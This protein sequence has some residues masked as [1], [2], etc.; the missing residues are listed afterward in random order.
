MTQSPLAVSREAPAFQ[1]KLGLFDATM[2]VAGS[3]IGSGIFAVSVGIARDVGSS[4]WLILVWLVSG[5]MTIIG[6]LSYAELASMFPHAGGQYVFLREAYGSLWAFLYGWTAFLVIQAGFIAAVAVIFATYLGV[7]FPNLGTESPIWETSLNIDLKVPVPWMSENVTFFKREKFTVSPGQFVAVV[8]IAVLTGLNCFGVGMGRWVQNIFTVAK[9]LGLLLLIVVGLT[10]AADVQFIATNA[11]DRWDGITSTQQYTQVSRFAPVPLLAVLLVLCGAM[12]GPLFS[13]DAWNNVTFTAGEVKNT[14]RNLPLSLGM[15][16]GMVILLYLLANVAYLCDLPIQGDAALAQKLKA[17]IDLRNAQADELA[18]EGRLHEAQ[19]A[20]QDAAAKDREATIAELKARAS[21]S[22]GGDL[23]KVVIVAL[24]QDVKKRKY[25]A[26]AFRDQAASSA[27]ASNA[28][29]DS[30]K[31]W[32]EEQYER[33]APRL[34]ISHARDDR[35]GTAV[36]ELF[37]PRFGVQ[38]MAL[39]IMISTFGCANGLILMGARLYY[40]MAKDGLFFQSVGRLN[41]F[42]VPAVGLILQ[43][44]WASL[45]AFS[46]TYGDLLYYVIFAALLF[47]ALTVVGL[48]VLRWKRPDAERPYKAIGYPV[49]PAIYVVLCTLIMLDLLV[50]EPTYTWPGLIIVLTGVP[51]YFL[52]RR[53][54]RRAQSIE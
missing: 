54:G 17:E 11:A 35:V 38:A 47:Y 24:E 48:F 29:R 10:W 41:R 25:E 12:V 31:Q 7:L 19:A 22:Q 50:V 27:A 36:M 44:I 33:A 13:S 2:L 9:T 5:V 40:A 51:A 39:A 43:A 34:G 26:D 42:G 20:V 49:L 16:T 8:M 46:G 30:T 52:W 37:S 1:Q 53:L 6:A 23:A 18:A 15:G 45:L 4:G 21:E 3:M 32:A 14:K 28:L